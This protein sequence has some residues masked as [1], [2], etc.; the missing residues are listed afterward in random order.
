MFLIISMKNTVLNVSNLDYEMKHVRLLDGITVAKMIKALQKFPSHYRLDFDP[1][2]SDDLT[3][4]C[5]LDIVEGDTSDG[6]GTVCVT[7]AD[8]G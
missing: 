4:G 2:D 3:D 6:P 8:S 5:I 7:L 1:N